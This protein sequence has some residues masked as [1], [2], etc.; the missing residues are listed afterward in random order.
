MLDGAYAEYV[1]GYDAGA[2]LVDARDNVVMTRTFSKIYGLGGPARRLGLR[3]RSAIIDALNRVRGPFNLSTAALAAAEAAVRDRA[4]VA[5]CR[6]ENAALAR[7]AGP[8]AGRDGRALGRGLGQ[9]HPRPLRRRGRG[10]RLRRAPARRGDH[11]APGRRATSCRH[12]LRITVGDE[13]SCR[14]VAAIGQFKGLRDRRGRA[15]DASIER[16]ALIGLG[17]IASSIAHA[18]APRRRWR[19]RSSATPAPPRPARR[20]A[21]ARLLRPGLRDARPRRSR[22]PTS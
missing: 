11:R 1:E 13:A 18:D 16:V 2:A 5:R 6:A 4:W 8:D 9:L 22:A 14:R 17:L 15:P 7:L 21:R 19:A 3:A 10:R 12:C 20:R